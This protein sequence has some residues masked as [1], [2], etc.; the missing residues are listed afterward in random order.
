MWV[1]ALPALFLAMASLY[2]K[3]RSPFWW[4]EFRDVRGVRHNESTKLRWDDV[5]QT[6]KAKGLCAQRSAGEFAAPARGGGEGWKWVE[7]WQETRYASNAGTR[8]RMGSAWAAVRAF[9]RERRVLLPRTLSREDCLAYFP[10]RLSAAAQGAGLRKAS[11]NTVLL[12]LKVLSSVMREAV[13]RGLA[14]ANPCLQL[15]LKRVRGKVKPRMTEEEI[16]AIEAALEVE[17]SKHA[18][19]LRISWQIATRQGCRLAETWVPLDDVDLREGTITFRIK[20]GREHTQTLHPDLVPLFQRLK[21]RGLSHPFTMPPSFSAAWTKF[22][23]RHGLGHLSFH[24][25]RVTVVSRLREERVDERVAMDFVGHSSVLVH[26]IYQRG[27]RAEQDAA[28]DALRRKPAGG[29]AS[30][31]SPAT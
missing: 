12:E 16:A 2:K 17:E 23:R 15:G 28:I 7:R 24:C 21:R 4:M 1:P 3:T 19:A 29:G 11:H 22:F 14:G 31:S 30:G 6:R 25:T 10:W 5:E 26:R 18:E 9:L 27:R 20:G 8:K 13:A